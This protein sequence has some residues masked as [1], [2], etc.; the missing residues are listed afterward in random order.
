MDVEIDDIDCDGFDDDGDGEADEDIVCVVE[1]DVDFD[2]F[3]GEGDGFD[4]DLFD[5]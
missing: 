3:D 1:F 2:G 4:E 5:N